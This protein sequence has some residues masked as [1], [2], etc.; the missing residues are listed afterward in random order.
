MG[1]NSHTFSPLTDLRGI[2][3]SSDATLQF[4][5]EKGLYSRALCGTRD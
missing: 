4:L 2:G 5:V 3:K 1:S